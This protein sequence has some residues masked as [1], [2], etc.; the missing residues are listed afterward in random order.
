MLGMLGSMSH[1][2]V[3]VRGIAH[4]EV[5]EERRGAAG[6][7]AAAAALA[8]RGGGTIREPLAQ[9]LQEPAA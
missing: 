2:G 6:T 7:S 4:G 3:A 9:P 8:R 1:V 5:R